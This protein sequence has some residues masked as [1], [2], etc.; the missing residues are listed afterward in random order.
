MLST[1]SFTRKSTLTTLLVSIAML[2]VVASVGQGD[3]SASARKETLTVTG[4]MHTARAAHT[5][6]LLHDGRVLITGGFAEDNE[7]RPFASAERYDPDQGVFTK[8]GS[9]T[10]GRQ[11]HT[12]TLLLDG[13]V[14]I[15]GGYDGTYLAGAELYDP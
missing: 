13:R 2:V 7:G 5:A 3:P 9:L 6:T 10:T 1:A 4:P 12:A 14:V 15:A 11:S 8:T